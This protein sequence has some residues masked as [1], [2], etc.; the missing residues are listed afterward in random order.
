MYSF[1]DLNEIGTINKP[2]LLEKPTWIT[3]Q[4]LL[5]AYANVQ[6]ILGIQFWSNWLNYYVIKDRIWIESIN[7]MNYELVA[8][9]DALT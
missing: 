3:I 9:H 6:L 4:V 1:K 2:T 8:K 7:Y 5:I